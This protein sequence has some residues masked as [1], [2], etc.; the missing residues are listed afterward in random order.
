MKGKLTQEVTDESMGS[1]LQDALGTKEHSGRVR[2]QSKYSSSCNSVS[3]PSNSTDEVTKLRREMCE[4]KTFI[5]KALTQNGLSLKDANDELP[6]VLRPT[7][8]D[9]EY[10][11]IVDGEEMA[12]GDDEEMAKG[13]DEDM[14]KDGD[15]DMGK[16][17]TSLGNFQFFNTGIKLNIFVL[18]FNNISEFIR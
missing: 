11:N 4:L 8:E 12:K 6:S 16:K 2:G 13:G 14:P 3:R 18:F 17:A 9:V 10:E 15:D 1:V 5:M 7:N